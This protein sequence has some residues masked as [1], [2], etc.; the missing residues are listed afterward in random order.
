MNKGFKIVHN[1]E[2]SGLRKSPS[3]LRVVEYVGGYSRLDMWLG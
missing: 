3:I 1:E 2:L